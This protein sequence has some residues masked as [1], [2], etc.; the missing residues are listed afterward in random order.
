MFNVTNHK[1][2]CKSIR[3]TMRYHVTPIGKSIVKKRKNNE[4]WQECGV[5]GILVH[6]GWNVN[7]D[8][9]YGKQY[10]GSSKN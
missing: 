10:G 5:K 4:C 2:N 6:C 7:G 9:H 8:S 3:S 1:G